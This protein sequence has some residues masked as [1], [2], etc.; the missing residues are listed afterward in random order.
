MHRN[1]SGS[2]LTHSS[3]DN[4]PELVIKVAKGVVQRVNNELETVKEEDEFE[5]DLIRLRKTSSIV[6]EDEDL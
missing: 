1:S 5:E 4:S 3:G 6:D 2:P